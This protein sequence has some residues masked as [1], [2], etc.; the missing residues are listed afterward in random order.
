MESLSRRAEGSGAL[1]RVLIVLLALVALP[2]STLALAFG[3][4]RLSW[5]LT[6]VHA[7]AWELPFTAEAV[8][9]LAAAVGG[10]L[11]LALLLLSGVASSAGLLA[12]AALSVLDLLLALRPGL[13]LTLT[14]PLSGELAD[15][16][17]QWIA[18]GIPL[19]LHLLL[20]GAGIALAIARRRPDPPAAGSLLGIVVVPVV[21]GAG[22]VLVLL[23]AFEGMQQALRAVELSVPPRSAVLVLL[24]A[25]LVLLSAAATRWSPWSGILPALALLGL[26]L[27]WLL[28]AARTVVIENLPGSLF[29]AVP[30]GV[31]FGGAAVA[32]VLLGVHTAVLAVV[33]RRARRR[34]SVVPG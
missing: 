29:T 25:V 10:L 27:V 22:V 14:E 9:A 17:R 8:A 21:M 7:P 18:S 15:A 19:L 1:A 28:P 24:G 11:L 5:F 16:L 13:I 20:G 2:L 4:G 34:L 3:T 33:R 30:I 23:G 6:Q 32:A 12:V 31:S 26:T